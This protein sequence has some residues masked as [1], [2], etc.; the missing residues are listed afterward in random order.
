MARTWSLVLV[1][2][3]AAAL[4]PAAPALKEKAATAPPIFGE[5]FRTGHTESGA[6][7]RVDNEQHHQVFTPEGQWQYWYG[8]RQGNATRNGFVTDRPVQICC[9]DQNH[10]LTHQRIDVR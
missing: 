8:A 5:W 1:L 4:A 2:L 3:P 10:R 9:L 6:P 7:V